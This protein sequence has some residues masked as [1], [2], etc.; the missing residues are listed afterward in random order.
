MCRQAAHAGGARN[1]AETSPEVGTWLGFSFFFAVLCI[2]STLMRLVHGACS[3]T[4][5]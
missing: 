2:S 1:L 5:F 3:K 4:D